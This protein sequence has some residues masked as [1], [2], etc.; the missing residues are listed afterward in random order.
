MNTAVKTNFC[1]IALI[2]VQLISSASTNPHRTLLSRSPCVCVY[3]CAYL[4]LYKH[5]SHR[6]KNN[7]AI[8]KTT[9]RKRQTPLQSCCCCCRLLLAFID[10]QQLPL[11]CCVNVVD[12]HTYKQTRTHTHPH[13]QAYCT[14]LRKC[15]PPL[16]SPPLS[17]LSLHVSFCLSLLAFLFCALYGIN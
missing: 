17:A 3:V 7:T 11:K 8:T 9:R 15:P 2:S 5:L 10:R 4:A 6:P 14:R 13:I 12:L 16:T 1:C